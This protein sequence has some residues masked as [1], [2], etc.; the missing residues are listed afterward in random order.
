M[1]SFGFPLKF[2]SRALQT[3]GDCCSP[4]PFPWDCSGQT[5]RASWGLPCEQNLEMLVDKLAEVAFLQISHK[6]GGVFS[7]KVDS[8]LPPTCPSSKQASCILETHFLGKGVPQGPCAQSP[9]QSPSSHLTGAELQDNK[10]T[11]NSKV[12][13]KKS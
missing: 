13:I 12:Q 8:L 5:F 10:A 4:F 3:L 2:T 7:L 1:N 11:S 6:S 9:E